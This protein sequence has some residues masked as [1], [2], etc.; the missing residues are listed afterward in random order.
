MHA[1]MTSRWTVAQFKTF[2]KKMVQIRSMVPLF[3]KVPDC[4]IHHDLYYFWMK[5]FRRNGILKHDW[6][7][8]KIREKWKYPKKKETRDNNLRRERRKTY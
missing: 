6:T 8:K 7:K 2:A 4:D 1:P 3:Q 5:I